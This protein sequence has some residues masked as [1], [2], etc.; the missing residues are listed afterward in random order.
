MSLVSD[1]INQSFL[2]LGAVAPGEGITTAEQ[3][4]AFLRL[5]QILGQWS[6]EQLSVYTMVHGNWPLV[7]GT[8]VYTLGTGGSL[9]T[10]AV[11]M[12]VTGAA[13]VSGAFRGP[14][15]VVSWDAFDARV[16]DGQGEVSVLPEILAADQAW[17]SINIRVHP[18]PAAAPGTLWLDYW[19]PLLAF[20]TVGDTIALPPGFEAALHWNLALN[21]Y[22][23][24][25]RPGATADVVAGMAQSTKASLV[26]LGAGVLGQTPQQGA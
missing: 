14:I 15:E 4:D 11:P 19:T 25:A 24:Y 23:Q 13:G 7:A 26:A 18:T 22:P 21:L 6:K 5:N 2:D 12:R 1:L 17:P 20:A 9:S 16:A 8:T 10:A 3:S